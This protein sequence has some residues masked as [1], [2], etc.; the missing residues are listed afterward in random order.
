MI[1]RKPRSCGWIVAVWLSLIGSGP[2]AEFANM[3]ALGA[4][5]GYRLY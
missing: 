5:S 4:A 1:N 2:A 3:A